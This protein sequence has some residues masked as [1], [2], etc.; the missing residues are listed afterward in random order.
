MNEVTRILNAIEQ[1]DPQAADQLLPLVYDELRRLASHKLAHEAPGQTLQPTAL[2]HEAYLRLVA[3][4]A[5]AARG[6]SWDGRGHFFAAAAEAMRRIP[7][8]TAR[9]KERGKHGGHLQRL[10]LEDRDV[11]VSPPADDILALYA[12]CTGHPPFRADSALAVLKRVSEDTP[13]SLRELNPA[14]PAWLEQVVVRLLAKDPAGRFASA[15][16]VAA[17]LSRCLQQLQAGALP[18][19]PMAELAPVRK[20]GL[21]DRMAV[22]TKRRLWRGVA[23]AL[24]LAGTAWAAW[25]LAKQASHSSKP[26]HDGQAEALPVAAVVLKPVH[27]LSQHADG[28]LTVAYS[29]DG[30]VLASAGKDQTIILWDV[31]TWKVRARLTGHA[32]DVNNLVFSP[33]N[34]RL[35]SVSSHPDNCCIRLW[36][37]QTATAAGTLGG[38]GSGMFGLDWSADGMWLACGGGDR[39][40]RVWEVASGKEHLVLPDVCPRYVRGLAFSPKADRIIA[41]G[42]GPTRLFDANTGQEIPAAFPAA[43]CPLFLPGGEAVV[44][45]IYQAGRVSICDYPSGQ[46]RGAWRAHPGGIEGLAVSPDG[47]FL[48]SLG[49]EGVARLWA[50]ADRSEVATLTGHQGSVYAAAF[51]P[52]GTRLATAGLADHTVRI[53]DLPEICRVAK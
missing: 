46:T 33:D 8:E 30:K 36:D 39:S 24:L 26:A 6:Q 14:L 32:G 9:R 10:A 22:F 11:P 45:W 18:S 51:S 1:G 21:L 17:V 15:A 25:Q 53:W 49:Q 27:T 47:R 7:V 41:G 43:M 35:A 38:P 5:A 4:G 42:T 2:V 28:V 3:E 44:G 23:L 50:T 20:P 13:R 40:V 48:V 29:P 16:E 34:T 31:G 52:D 12:L 37:V 19:Q